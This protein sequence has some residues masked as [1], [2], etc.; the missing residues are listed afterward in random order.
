MS[1]MVTQ[2]VTDRIP[3]NISIRKL[4]NMGKCEYHVSIPK[5][6]SGL[7]L[8]GYLKL[9]KNEQ[10]ISREVESIMSIPTNQGPREMKS[11]TELFDNGSSSSGPYTLPAVVDLKR[12][13][14]VEQKKKLCHKHSVYRLKSAV[15]T[16][17]TSF[18][19]L[20]NL[21][22]KDVVIVGSVRIAGKDSL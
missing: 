14:S 2:S 20:S 10:S 17:L 4:L 6:V 19:R 7:G 16:V 13:V 5:W 15:Q 22:F 12:T 18:Q 11:L 1:S 8:S 3:D 21:I 9:I